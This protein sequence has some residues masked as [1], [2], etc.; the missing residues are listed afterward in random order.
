MPRRRALRHMCKSAAVR[1]RSREQAHGEGVR[2]NSASTAGRKDVLE[3]EDLESTWS[4]VV[5]DPSAIVM[6]AS[7]GP[8]M[9]L[10]SSRWLRFAAEAR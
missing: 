7:R 9:A 1:F 3:G 8:C 5:S 6:G 4:I 10:A 2:S